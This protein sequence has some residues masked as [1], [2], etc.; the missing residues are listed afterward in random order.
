MP[1]NDSAKDYNWRKKNQRRIVLY[2]SRI[3]ENDIIEWIESQPSM[4][5]A[6]KD[7]IRKEIER[8]SQ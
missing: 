2:L 7:L 8:E 5:G 3:S 1:Y 6:I 4:Q